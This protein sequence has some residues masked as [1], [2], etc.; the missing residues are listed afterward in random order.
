MNVFKNRTPLSSSL[1]RGNLVGFQEVNERF[2]EHAVGIR[3]CYF[4]AIAMELI[5]ISS[6]PARL[7]E[8][9]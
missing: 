4:A 9:S 3:A 8:R 7:E 6:V 1:A 5:G 2:L